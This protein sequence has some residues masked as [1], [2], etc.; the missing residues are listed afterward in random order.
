[1]KFEAHR[2]PPLLEPP[3]AEKAEDRP[4]RGSGWRKRYLQRL[5]TTVQIRAG[6]KGS[7]KIRR[8]A[9]RA[10]IIWIDC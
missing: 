10:S 8:S 2:R 3:H 7:G 5:G 1:M 6:R 9:I 4:R